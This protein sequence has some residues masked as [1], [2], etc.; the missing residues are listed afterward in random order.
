[1]AFTRLGVF[2]PPPSSVPSA[3]RGFVKGAELEPS[4]LRYAPLAPSAKI[5]SL[6][7]QN[8]LVE[9]HPV[10]PSAELSVAQLK[11]E[12]ERL[13]AL[14]DPVEAH[15]LE[16]LGFARAVPVRFFSARASQLVDAFEHDPRPV[17]ICVS[18]IDRSCI[19]KP[20]D[21]DD[22]PG[23]AIPISRMG[24]Q[25][26]PL[27]KRVYESRGSGAVR[28][29]IRRGG[30][31]SGAIEAE[32]CPPNADSNLYLAVLRDRGEEQS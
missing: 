17:V 32:L 27:I 24:Q 9:K 26:S 21:P 10:P 4:K 12:R 6:T 29:G 19:L 1:M 7:N 8:A 30:K 31:R 13:R 14:L 20:A 25:A 28:V 11:A 15:L 2:G 16:R 23:E 5:D 3:R 18:G 22:L